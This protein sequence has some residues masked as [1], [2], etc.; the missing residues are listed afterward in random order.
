M[1]QYITLAQAAQIAGYRHDHTLRAA[2][3]KGKL[4]AVQFGPRARVT[5]RTWLEEYL[6][7]VKQ[8]GMPRGHER[9]GGEGV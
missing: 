9:A 6:A 2:T 4:K 1:D 5:T 7:S 3:R 8:R